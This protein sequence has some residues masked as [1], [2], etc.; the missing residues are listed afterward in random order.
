MSLKERRKKFKKLLIRHCAGSY[1]IIGMRAAL[2][3]D[4]RI[5][6]SIDIRSKQYGKRFVKLAKKIRLMEADIRKKFS[7]WNVR[8][9]IWPDENALAK[10]GK[11]FRG[12]KIVLSHPHKL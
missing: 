8:V 2:Y 11:P 12:K 10:K 3:D 4:E 6:V 7:G 9:E 1:S 5:E